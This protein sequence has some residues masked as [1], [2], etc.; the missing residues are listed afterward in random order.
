MRKPQPKSIR[1]A[2]DRRVPA[3]DC[4]SKPKDICHS[5]DRTCEFQL[6]N[7]RPLL[8]AVLAILVRTCYI[9]W[10]SKIHENHGGSSDRP[11]T[12]ESS[13][14]LKVSTARALPYASSVPEILSNWVE[15]VRLFIKYRHNSRN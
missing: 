6:S 11:Q 9:P 14:K 5:R 4:D 8:S 10:T 13:H 15:S 2:R 7:D 1:L 3:R 12:S